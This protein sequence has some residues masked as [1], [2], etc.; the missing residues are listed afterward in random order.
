MAAVPELQAKTRK[1]I[2]ASGGIIG[3]LNYSGFLIPVGDSVHSF[4]QPKDGSDP[5]TP[6]YCQ[7][8]VRLP[9]NSA[10]DPRI[11]T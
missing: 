4:F 3:I 6:P 2:G 8:H 7:F 9:S 11:P 1:T 10:H 5:V